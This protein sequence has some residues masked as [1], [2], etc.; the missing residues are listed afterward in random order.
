MGLR[1]ILLFLLIAAGCAT[2]PPEGRAVTGRVDQ[3]TFPSAIVNDSYR[4]EVRLP[5]SLWRRLNAPS[6]RAAGDDGRE[7][8]GGG[9]D[10]SGS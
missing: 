2:A 4:I 1:T 9:D 3:E 8:V 10:A 6:N 5:P 7:A